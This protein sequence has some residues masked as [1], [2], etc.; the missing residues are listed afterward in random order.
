MRYKLQH[1]PGMLADWELSR[2]LKDLRAIIARTPAGAPERARLQG[3]ADAVMAEQADRRRTRGM[4]GRSA[5][6]QGT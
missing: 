2:S 1:P 4:A 5:I 3:L 6:P